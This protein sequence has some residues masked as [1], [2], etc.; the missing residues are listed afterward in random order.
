V[1]KKKCKLG[2]ECKEATGQYRFEIVAPT[3]HEEPFSPTAREIREAALEWAHKHLANAIEFLTIPKFKRGNGRNAVDTD[4]YL[5][6]LAHDW[7]HL[8]RATKASRPFTNPDTVNIV[9]VWRLADQFEPALRAFASGRLAKSLDREQIATA[10]RNAGAQER[11]LPKHVRAVVNHQ[12][13]PGQMLRAVV[14]LESRYSEATVERYLKA[15]SAHRRMRTTIEREADS[16]LG[17]RKPFH[18]R[19]A[20][21]VLALTR[22]H[23]DRREALQRRKKYNEFID[24][25]RIIALRQQENEL[26]G[27]S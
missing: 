17:P 14:A 2:F 8:M 23:A 13:Q 27:R 11:H 20:A 16:R 12:R 21:H 22:R 7:F 4:A 19:F 5:P 25:Y 6:A 9:G 15:R 24:W 3:A 18:R 26:L 1:R 10:L